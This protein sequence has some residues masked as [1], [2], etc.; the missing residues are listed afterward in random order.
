MIFLKF[1][2][3]YPKGWDIDKSINR[4]KQTF[5]GNKIAAGQTF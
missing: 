1:S 5:P 3:S 2:S 4:F